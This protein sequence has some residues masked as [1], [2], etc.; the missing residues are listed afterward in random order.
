LDSQNVSVI[1]G[2][3]VKMTVNVGNHP[4]YSAYDGGNGYVYVTNVESKNVAAISTPPLK[5]PGPSNTFLGLPAAEGY[6]RLG[7]LAV[8]VVAAAAVALILLRRRRKTRPGRVT[9]P[10]QSGAG[11]PPTQP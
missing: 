8:V 3:P 4:Q 5:E 10:P 2:T 7:V 6:V 9:I 11:A 1:S